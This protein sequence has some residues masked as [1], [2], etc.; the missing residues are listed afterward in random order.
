MKKKIAS[1][2]NTL[3]EFNKTEEAAGMELRL[4]LSELILKNLKRKGWTQRELADAAQ[5]KESLISRLV[6]ADS[7]CTLDTAAKVLFALGVRVSLEETASTLGQSKAST[8]GIIRLA[9]DGTHGQIQE[10]AGTA[11]TH[12]IGFLKAHSG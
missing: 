9:R 5:V 10:T 2:L 7:N 1:I 4:S 11:R 3:A 8:G 12:Q 6:H